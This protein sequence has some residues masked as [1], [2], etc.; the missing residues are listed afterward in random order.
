VA[1]P[2][3]LEGT[4]GGCDWLHLSRDA[5]RAA[6]EDHVRRILP[7]SARSVAITLHDDAPTV[8]YRTRARLHA[9]GDRAG[10]TLGFHAARSRSLVDVRSC[11]VLDPRLDAA[12]G[13]LRDV[14]LGARGEGEVSIALGKGQKP[15]FVLRWGEPLP[16]SVYR[17]VEERV[18]DGSVG[19]AQLYEPGSSRPA[20]VGDPAPVMVGADGLPLSLSSGGFAQ[21]SELVNTSLARRVLA[22]AESQSPNGEAGLVELYAGAGN[23]TVLLAKA[24]SRVTTLEAD[25]QACAAAR[26]NLSLR[27]LTAKVTCADADAYVPKAGTEIVVLDPPRRGA[28]ELSVALAASRV[29]SVVYVSCDAPTLGRDLAALSARFDVTAV[30]SFGM[31]PGTSH[32]ETIVLLTARSGTGA[33]TGTLRR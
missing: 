30:E 9:R 13:P 28:K 29:K 22:L 4:C 12:L 32:S 18:N 15:V 20:I 5:Q 26:A 8:G 33:R 1:P 11:A 21:S 19:G 3:P 16:P 27:G 6:R 25:E 2:C 7:E 14:L 10:V 24:F 31:F 23:F 17:R